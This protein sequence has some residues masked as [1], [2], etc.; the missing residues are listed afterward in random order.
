[1][2]IKIMQIKGLHQIK[3][4]CSLKLTE[5]SKE[6]REEIFKIGKTT[7]NEVKTQYTY[8][9]LVINSWVSGEVY[10]NLGKLRELKFKVIL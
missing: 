7:K 4:N 2:R 10:I 8:K 1:M 3:I 6:S 5:N 9:F